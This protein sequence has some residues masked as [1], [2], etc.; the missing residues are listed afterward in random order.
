MQ[1]GFYG[2]R[3]RSVG[4]VFSIDFLDFILLIFIFSLGAGL[5]GRLLA[6]LIMKLYFDWK[7]KA[8]KKVGELNRGINK[9]SV[10]F[11]LSAFITAIAYSLGVVAIL[12]DKMFNTHTLITLMATY[13]VLKI[14]IYFLV[15]YLELYL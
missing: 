6:Y 2:A 8:M 12:Q 13:L 9:V 15:K 3:D 5:L 11:F 1:F 7:R 4:Y 14:G 10:G